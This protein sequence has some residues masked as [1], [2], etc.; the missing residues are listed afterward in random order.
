M[1]MMTSVGKVVLSRNI[2]VCLGVL[3]V[4]CGGSEVAPG[5]GILPAGAVCATDSSCL[6][7][8]VCDDGTCRQVC[9]SDRE[10]P[11][12]H[13]CDDT[14]CLPVT[15]PGC[16]TDDACLASTPPACRIVT[17]AE[18]WAG[19]CH[20]QLAASGSVCEDGNP[21]TTGTTCD[22]AGDCGGGSAVVCDHPPANEC[23][24]DSTCSAYTSAGSCNAVTGDCSYTPVSTPTNSGACASECGGCALRFDGAPC[25]L[26]SGG[27]GVCD[28]A[29]CVE[30][31]ADDDCTSPPTGFSMCFGDATCDLVSNTCSYEPVVGSVLCAAAGCYGGAF[32]ND[33]YC[34]GGN[35]P[36]GTPTS[37]CGGF[38]CTAD[39]T[40]C[41]TM[42]GTD[43]EC[44]ST[45]FC[46]FTGDCTEKYLDGSSCTYLT[47]R[48]CASG[49]CTGQLCC[50]DGVFCCDDNTN[51][52]GGFGCGLDNVCL[53]D[54]GADGSALCGAGYHCRSGDCIHD[55]YAGGSC[56]A[57]YDC[58]SGHCDTSVTGPETGR[59]CMAGECCDSDGV[60]DCPAGE[61][62]RESLFVCQDGAVADGCDDN[63]DCQA[64]LYCNASGACAP[65]L[66]IG[67]T[68]CDEPSDCVAGADVICDINA[69]ALT[70][71]CCPSLGPVDGGVGQCCNPGAGG[72]EQCPVDTY[73]VYDSGGGEP[74]W[75][76]LGCLTGGLGS[77]CY[78]DDDCN[79]SLD[80]SCKDVGGQL[81]CAGDLALDGSTDCGVGSDCLG[82]TCDLAV[83]S[84]ASGTHLCCSDNVSECCIFASDCGGSTPYCRD[85]TRSCVSGDTGAP[86]DVNDDCDDICTYADVCAAPLA[87]G[88]MSCDE[89]ADCV[90]GHCDDAGAEIH[91]CCPDDSAAGYTGQCCDA[92]D[93]CLS[94]HCYAAT[95]GCV[96]GTEGSKCDDGDD[97]AESLYCSGNVCAT[98]GLLAGEVCTES[99]QCEGTL[100][101]GPSS[102]TT[103]I[104]CSSGDCCKTSGSPII[105]CG[106]KC[107]L[108]NC[109]QLVESCGYQDLCSDHD[110]LCCSSSALGGLCDIDGHEEGCSCAGA[111]LSQE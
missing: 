55:V 42:C 99:E 40:A 56:A 69:P 84:L 71:V 109:L 20:Y 13:D 54:C 110:D 35:C 33:R 97:C 37:D 66:A 38:G 58:A 81:R 96:T 90:S 26:G 93:D 24:D 47:G 50:E 27:S 34:T 18:C 8:L 104:C 10:C 51:C 1:S 103:K 88:A 28:G 41:L 95:S 63:D 49:F 7:G 52:P 65:R 12:D 19:T 23:T 45:H 94:G 31:L 87:D 105:P 61:L 92:D 79:T 5:G 62:C 100:L 78:D 74:E 16:T 83:P 4:G 75:A 77:R 30:C 102:A 32:Y 108:N 107:L 67:A 17:G 80:L 106:G 9:T 98:G 91:R 25:A 6:A 64:D 85:S 70:G 68:G 73:C 43:P 21:C 22:A 59:C 57:D 36:L 89:D 101:C 60:D 29:L 76:D 14:V 15:N 46:D 44:A 111:C 2:L 72:G 48:E 53:D 86:C 11:K 82:G 39:H 3:L